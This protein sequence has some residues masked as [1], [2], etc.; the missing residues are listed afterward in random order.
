MIA[1]V[2]ANAGRPSGP[3]S[4]VSSSCPNAT[5]SSALNS[6]APT[7]A[8]ERN[9]SASRTTAMATPTSSPIGA[10][11]CEP[12]SMTCPRAATLKLGPSALSPALTRFSPSAFATSM[13][14]RSYCTVVWAIV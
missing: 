11:C 10:S 5:P 9:N 12:A 7:A 6:V 3:A 13:A 1:I 8:N 14:A 4:A 2:D